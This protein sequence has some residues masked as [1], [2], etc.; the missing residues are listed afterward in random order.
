MGLTKPDPWNY[1][2]L[3]PCRNP[4]KGPRLFDVFAYNVYS[5]TGQSA[6]AIATATSS[7]LLRDTGTAVPL[8]VGEYSVNT[9]KCE[10][11]PAHCVAH[12]TLLLFIHMTSLQLL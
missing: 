8:S 2:W 10:L 12:M 4:A 3:S 7:G 9:A 11:A 6:A 1:I 5:A